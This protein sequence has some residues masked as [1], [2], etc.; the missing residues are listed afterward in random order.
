MKTCIKIYLFTEAKYLWMT[1]TLSGTLVKGL[2]LY[3]HYMM[4]RACGRTVFVS[5]HQNLNM[6]T[7]IACYR[8]H[9]G[10]GIPKDTVV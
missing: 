1:K 2:F 3:P 7:V 6:G 10:L 4:T 5:S 8:P 9:P